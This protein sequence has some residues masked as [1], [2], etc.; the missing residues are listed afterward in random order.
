[1]NA[2]RIRRLVRDV[3][4]AAHPDLRCQLANEREADLQE[5]KARVEAETASTRNEAE[6]HW[7]ALTGESLRGLPKLSV[8]E[9]S[10]ITMRRIAGAVFTI[11]DIPL[12][13]WLWA[14]ALLVD[15]FVAFIVGAI[16]SVGITIGTDFSLRNFADDQERPLRSMRICR[17][18]ALIAGIVLVSSAAIIFLMR[19]ASPDMGPLVTLLILS[20]PGAL[21]LASIS[22]P[23]FAGALFAW[24]AFQGR[25]QW[26]R[27]KLETLR[28]NLFE[29]NQ[30]LAKID[31]LRG[32]SLKNMQSEAHAGN[33][34]RPEPQ[35]EVVGNDHKGTLV[36][37]LLFT[38]LWMAAGEAR[39][40]GLLPHRRDLLQPRSPQVAGNSNSVVHGRSCEVWI[41]QSSS[42]NE[43]DRTEA[44]RR[45]N[46]H[47][48]DF[49]NILQCVR[50][51]AG[52]FTD[53]GR[54]AGFAEFEIPQAS[55]LDCTR[56]A[57]KY[58]SVFSL[59][60]AVEE[61]KAEAECA[62]RR[63]DV[64][65]RFEAERAAV[66]VDIEKMVAKER[67]DPTRERCTDIIG[68]IRGRLSM[69]ADPTL[70]LIVTDGVNDCEKSQMPTID[71]PP[72][73]RVVLL[74]LRP[75]QRKVSVQI[76]E[77]IGMWQRAVPDAILVPWV[78]FAPSW[79]RHLAAGIGGS[80]G[81]VQDTSR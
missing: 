7:R 56:T 29:L 3:E 24:S 40:A 35:L 48:G 45:V 21:W 43:D 19:S 4:E 6:E 57:T 73:V 17:T 25:P 79:I 68:L 70:L 5:E 20:V 37:L 44:L 30:A 2:R 61:K 15:V 23:L 34:S 69:V 78:N 64:N 81:M 27:R 50:I 18:V 72:G 60:K 28:R 14:S 52:H 12:G 49:I 67:R 66:L 26:Y 80:G 62:T 65:Q 33:G 16:V 46:N 42:V 8:W 9:R 75:D 76:D 63:Q 11:V 31:K 22:L 10:K 32:G 47:L 39:A 74:V 54:F 53:Q 38:A 55:S 41:D 36:G 59:F 13:A 77:L 58:A 51:R 71:V 1:M